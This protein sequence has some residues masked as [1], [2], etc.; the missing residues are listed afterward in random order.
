M[1]QERQDTLANEKCMMKA[2]CQRIKVKSTK[3]EM[4]IVSHIRH[5]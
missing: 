3:L 2:I 5:C 1:C 4:S